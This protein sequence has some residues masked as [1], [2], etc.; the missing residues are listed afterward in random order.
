MSG[1]QQTPTDDCS[2]A[3]P[4]RAIPLREARARLLDLLAPVSESEELPLV[5]LADR[6]LAEAIIAPIGVPGFTNAAMDGYALR[7]ADGTAPRRLVGS[8]LAGRP[9]EG[10]VD[11][12]QAVRI[13]TGAVL[14]AGADT[15]V[16]QE[17]VAREDDAVILQRAFRAGDNVRLA[18][19]DIPSGSQALPAGSRLRA[20]E[21]GVLAS[22][23]LDRA[24]VLRRLRVALL[25]TGDELVAPGQPLAAGQ[26]YD[27][28]SA[29]LRVLLRRLGVEAIDLGRVGDDATTLAGMLRDAAAQV[30]AIV[31]SGGVSV[32]DADHVTDTIRQLGSLHVWKVAMKPGRPLAVGRIGDS[33]VF[34]LPGNPV[35]VMATFHQLVQPALQR[36]MGLAPQAPLQLRARLLEPLRKKPG[37][38][39]FQRGVL[40][41]DE[42]G[43][44][45]V[46]GVGSQGSAILSSMV[47]ADCFIVLDADSGPPAAGDE[48]DVQ[49]FAGFAW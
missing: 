27:S 34:G 40:G 39:E 1:P 4:G 37:R 19:E 15:V 21:I 18:G 5:E 35:S 20:A 2:A 10:F 42:A 30:D 36:L 31:T 43:R 11:A 26:I 9:F 46:R 17:H 44:T 29:T 25:A 32:G 28:N 41:R 7:A 8:A 14:P 6:V 22:L 23:G 48:V 3:H 38:V 13:F 45:T 49:P 24:R 47:R 33:W 12:G 16:M